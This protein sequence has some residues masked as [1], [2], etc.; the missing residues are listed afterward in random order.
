MAFAGS[1]VAAPRVDFNRDVRPILGAYCVQCH[2]PDERERKAG[3]RLDLEETAR[4]ANEHGEIAIVPGEPAKSGLVRRIFST[5]DAVRMP[6]PETKKRLTEA[7]RETLRTW[8]GQGA[9]YSEHWA[10]L[11]ISDPPLPDVKGTDW[12]RNGID[13]FILA[14][15]ERE[16][17]AP[18]TEASAGTL[19]RRLYLDLTGLLPSPEAVVEFERAFEASTDAALEGLAGKLLP[20]DAHGERWGRHW[21]DQARYADSHGY[22]IDGDRIMWPYRDWV[23]RAI[24]DDMPFDQFTIEQLAGDL[25][26]TPA[27]SQLVAT[28]FHRN[29]LINQ[30]GGT[31]NEQFRNEEVVDRVNTTGA[32]WLGLTVGCAQCHTHKFDPITQREYF[33]LFD[34]FNHTED[35]NNQG[36]TVNVH[37]GELLGA[38]A[39]PKRLAELKEAERALA[40]LERSR[41]RRQAVWE[42]SWLAGLTIDSPADW[43]VMKP[44][45]VRAEHGS[46]LTVLEDSS[47]LGAIGDAARENYFVDLQ[48]G[49]IDP[50]AAIRLRVIPHESLPKQGPGLAGNGNFVLTELEVL[51]GDRTIAITRAEADHAQPG[52]PIVNVIDGDPETG[53]AINVGKGTPNGVKMNAPHEA[54]FTFAEPVSAEGGPLRVVL[55]HEKNSHYNIGRFA[56][57]ASASEPAPLRS[58]KLLLA[59]KTEPA[60]RTEGQ[61]K[62]IAAEFALADSELKSAKAAVETARRRL[63]YG[64]PVKAMVMRELSKPRDTY[65]HIRGDFL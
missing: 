5:D 8:I 4:R 9:E 11:P 27:L 65:V 42:K 6:P 64:S 16:K 46:N 55:H 60:K 23:I 17:I 21:L 53:W 30:E 26:P 44:A 15:L 50:V 51:Q 24:R 41:T 35:V 45:A 39:D 49:R 25:L 2:G 29:T 48:W 1:S 22:T 61:K 38:K 33:E 32:V 56:I 58:E 19:I 52:F 34:F 28:G 14:R 36:P 57:D 13:H 20:T 12:V 43:E 62:E 40:E 7:Q 54:S 18:S 37:A 10:F 59:I 47:V 63:G 31:D 3:L